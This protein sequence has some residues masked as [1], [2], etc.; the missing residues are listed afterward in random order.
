MVWERKYM[1]FDTV[2]VRKI[3]VNAPS[4]ACDRECIE[5]QTAGMRFKLQF[6]PQTLT[7][8]IRPK[9]TNITHIMIPEKPANTS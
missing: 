7:S 8:L 9:R 2:D 6:F 1:A 3:N 4:L 5:P